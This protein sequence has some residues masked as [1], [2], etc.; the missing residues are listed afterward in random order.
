MCCY[1]LYGVGWLLARAR[2]EGGIVLI[3]PGVKQGACELRP[4]L[5]GGAG[6]LERP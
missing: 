2:R 3:V 6:W 5:V 1:L 4:T